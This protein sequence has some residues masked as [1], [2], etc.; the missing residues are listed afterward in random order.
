MAKAGALGI[1][2]AL[3][4][5][6]PSGAANSRY[7]RALA[8]RHKAE[9][10]EQGDGTLGV[11]MRRVIEPFADRGAILIGTDTPSLP[12]PILRCYVALLRRESV[13]LGPSLDGGYYLL[14][15]RGAMPDI[16]RGVR[17]G[18]SSVLADT[19]GRLDRQQFRYELGPWWYDVDRWRDLRLLCTDLRR[20][21]TEAP[22]PCPATR[23]VLAR[24]GLFRIG[25]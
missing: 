1:P 21:N 7:F 4:G 17:W 16:F 2:V 20:P 12:L 15:V 5:D 19:I 3:A 8:R 14:G 9:L 11:R 18:S 22:D 10:I 25:G 23:R 13:V 6:A 24:L